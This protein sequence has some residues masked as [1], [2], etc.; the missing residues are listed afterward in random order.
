MMSMF[1]HSLKPPILYV[2]A[3]FPLWKIMSMARDLPGLLR[4]RQQGT[5]QNE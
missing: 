1:F 2:S 5:D 4:Q 3:I